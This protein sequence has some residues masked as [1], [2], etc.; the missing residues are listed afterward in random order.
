MP[1]DDRGDEELAIVRTWM[2]RSAA[3]SS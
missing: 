2:T 1:S 3:T